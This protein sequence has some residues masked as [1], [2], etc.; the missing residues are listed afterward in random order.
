MNADWKKIVATVAPALGAALGGPLVGTAVGAISN[1]V[2]GKP[3]GTEAEVAAAVAGASPDLLLKLKE[4]DAQFALDMKR[5]ELDVFNAE[6]ADRDSARQMF[7]VNVWP[8]TVAGGLFVLAFFVTLMVV[9]TGSIRTDE[10]WKPVLT[11]LLGMMGAGV[12][13]FLAWLYGST[14]GSREKTLALA[15][16]Q[17]PAAKETT[18]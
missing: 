7:K 4:A 1:A 10:A 3:D 17:P 15:S 5:L 11:T 16:S 6:A 9:L 2:L 14:L 13:Q 8:Q 12:T 18:P